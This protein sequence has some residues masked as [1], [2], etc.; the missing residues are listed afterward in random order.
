MTAL[1]TENC[2]VLKVRSMPT[3]KLKRSCCQLGMSEEGG[4]WALL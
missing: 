2:D 1:K 4:S 3:S